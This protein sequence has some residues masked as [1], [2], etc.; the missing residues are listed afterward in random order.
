MLLNISSTTKVWKDQPAGYNQLSIGPYR[1]PFKKF[2]E[3]EFKES[4]H[5]IKNPVSEPL[6]IIHR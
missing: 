4:D 6:L 3:G 1:N 5:G 2:G